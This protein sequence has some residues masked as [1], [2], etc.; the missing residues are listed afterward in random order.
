MNLFLPFGKD[1]GSQK[2]SLFASS[3]PLVTQ[4]VAVETKVKITY[5][6]NEK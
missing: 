1:Y 4:T 2:F 5:D 3:H 6:A